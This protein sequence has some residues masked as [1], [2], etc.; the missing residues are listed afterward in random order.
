MVGDFGEVLV[1]GWENA[2]RIRRENVAAYE[3]DVRVDIA[4]LGD[5]LHYVLTL[6]VAVPGEKSARP[7]KE[8]KVPKGLWKLMARIRADRAATAYPRVKQIQM[9]IGEFR[10]ELGPRRGRATAFDAVNEYL[11]KWH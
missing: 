9:E 6:V 8:W 5:L 2:K 1:A 7:A 11:Q 3:E 10:E 4:G